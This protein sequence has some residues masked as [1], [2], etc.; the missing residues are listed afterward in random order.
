MLGELG[1][2][3]EVGLVGELGL[4]AVGLLDEPFALSDEPFA[5]SDE[6]DE[7]PEELAGVVAGA[8][9]AA[10]PPLPSEVFGAAEVD[11]PRESFR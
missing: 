11:A 8:G 2:L 5:L 4:V 10:E 6:L 7:L 3:D 1:L 9:V